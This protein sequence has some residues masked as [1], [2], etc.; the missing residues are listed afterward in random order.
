MN[1]FN[2]KP[3]G[4]RVQGWAIYTLGVKLILGCGPDTALLFLFVGHWRA[5][6]D[7]KV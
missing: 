2:T 7:N 1:G 5:R 6:G 4:G 3:D